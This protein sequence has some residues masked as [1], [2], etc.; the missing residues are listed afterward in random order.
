MPFGISEGLS[1]MQFNAIYFRQVK[2]DATCSLWQI[3]I[4]INQITGDSP[5]IFKG[6]YRSFYQQNLYFIIKQSKIL[7]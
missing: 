3:F 2:Q 5:E 4:R 1:L 6:I 7:H